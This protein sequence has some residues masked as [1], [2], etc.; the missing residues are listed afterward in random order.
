MP[1]MAASTALPR[2][3]LAQVAMDYNEFGE[4]FAARR[5]LPPIMVPERASEYLHWDA[6][7]GMGLPKTERNIDGSIPTMTREHLHRR[8]YSCTGDFLQYPVDAVDDEEL[9]AVFDIDGAVVGAQTVMRTLE[10][11]LEKR[12]AGLININT[13]GSGYNTAGPEINRNPDSADVEKLV[14]DGHNAVFQQCG[15]YPNVVLM[16]HKT[17]L[18]LGRSEQVR[19]RV[20]YTTT[21]S[22]IREQAQGAVILNEE[23]LANFFNVDEIIVGEVQEDTAGRGAEP[24]LSKIWSEDLILFARIARGPRL[25][26]D[27]Q[28]GRTFCWAPFCGP[29]GEVWINPPYG[30]DPLTSFVPGWRFTDPQVFNVDA[31]HLFTG[32]DADT[33]GG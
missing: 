28:M 13:F 24:S 32:I 17:R 3:P 5:L 8:V 31:G 16:S 18:V 20:I 12:V 9:N 1:Q 2:S 6:K 25:D 22:R 29:D 27:V 19:E 30:R 21:S 23:A 11:K 7:K 33:S 10:R 15:A 4:R 26:A 14:A